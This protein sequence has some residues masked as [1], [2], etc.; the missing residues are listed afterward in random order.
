MRYVTARRPLRRDGPR[1]LRQAL[2]P[3]SSRQ[4]VHEVFNLGNAA[5]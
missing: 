4:E 5:I 1:G 2:I 3:T